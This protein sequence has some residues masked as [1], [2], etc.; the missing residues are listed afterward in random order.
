MTVARESFGFS[1]SIAVNSDVGR[2][3]SNN[4]DSHAHNWMD[5]GGLFVM[6]ADGMGGHEAGEVASG[7][8]VRV[9]EEVVVRDLAEDPRSRIY[10]SLIEANAAI[11][12]EASVSGTKGM[13][14]TAVVALAH[15]SEVFLGHIGDS[16]CY[17]IRDGHVV[18]R[19]RDHTRVQG[20]VDDG[21]LTEAQARVHPESGMLTR[22]LGHARMANGESLE[23]EVQEESFQLAEDDT[24]LL[25]SDGLTDLVECWEIAQVVAGKTSDQA[26]Q[27]LIDLACARGGH[28]NVTVAVINAGD[29]AG[30][31]DPAL[32][33]PETEVTVEMMDLESVEMWSEM[34]DDSLSMEQPSEVAAAP[35]KQGKSSTLYIAIAAVVMVLFFGV[36]VVDLVAAY[37]FKVL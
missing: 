34:G 37:Y 30:K 29:A 3:R 25:C 18:W 21:E 8:A 36:L 6:V 2:V 4:E 26:V 9:V 23:P 11:L 20:L 10:N 16:R 12:E 19:T 35:L 27:Q 15:G 24:L 7:L 1:L 32:D 14:T 13:G 22:A 31:Y 5:D 17:H 33:E 28:D